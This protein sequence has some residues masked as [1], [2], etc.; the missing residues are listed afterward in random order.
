MWASDVGFQM[1]A[2][3]FGWVRGVSDVCE[4][5]GSRG[6]KTNI[7][8]ATPRLTSE[9]NSAKTSNFDSSL[10]TFVSRDSRD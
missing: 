8:R 1:G 9:F 5:F 10:P 2:R 7:K 4:G 3:V 6:L